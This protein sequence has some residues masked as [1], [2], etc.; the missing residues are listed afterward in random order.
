MQQRVS[1]DVDD[2][3]GERERAS[4]LSFFERRESGCGTEMRDGETEKGRV[5]KRKERRGRRGRGGVGEEEGER[6]A[7]QLSA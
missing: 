2:E 7:A 6:E 1:H 5:Q 3:Q 4:H